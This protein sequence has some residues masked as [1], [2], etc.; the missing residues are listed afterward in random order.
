METSPA[1]TE[2]AVTEQVRQSTETDTQVQ[3]RPLQQA[4]PAI[5]EISRAIMVQ[6]V[7]EHQAA[8]AETDTSQA[9]TV[10]AVLQ[11]RQLPQADTVIMQISHVPTQAQQTAQSPQYY[12]V[13]DTGLEQHAITEISLAR[14]EVQVTAQATAP[15][16]QV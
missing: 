2:V 10:H 12:T 5:T 1:Q 16:A 13:T 6:E 9:Q 7:T 4:S 14:M 15:T 11:Q 8:I 3:T